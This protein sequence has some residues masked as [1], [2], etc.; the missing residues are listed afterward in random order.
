M[1]E[2]A[3]RSEESWGPLAYC[4]DKIFNAMINER[5][6]RAKDHIKVY[7][8]RQKKL[9]KYKIYFIKELRSDSFEIMAEDEYDVSSKAKQFFKE[10][11][12]TIGFVEKPRGKWAGDYA[13]YDKLSYVKV[14]S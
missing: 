3:N 12:N 9:K 11:E 2:V 4:D 10:N 14:V 13:G 8:K 5:R 7:L 1:F 6:E